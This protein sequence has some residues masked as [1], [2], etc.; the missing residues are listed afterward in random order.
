M[1]DLHVFGVLLL[2]VGQNCLVFYVD[3]SQFLSLRSCLLQ[4]LNIHFAFGHSPAVFCEE[5]EFKYRDYI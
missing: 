4:L 2:E 3:L 1:K 5:L